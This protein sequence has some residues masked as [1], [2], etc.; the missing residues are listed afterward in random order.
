MHDP[1]R[2]RLDAIDAVLDELPRWCAMWPSLSP[3]RQQ[4]IRAHWAIIRLH[5][6][7]IHWNWRAYSRGDPC[8]EWYVMLQL[9]I[10]EATPM[11]AFMGLDMPL[12][13]VCG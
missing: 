1:L 4:D 9:R 13:T 6:D 10:E 5:L 8:P 12:L 7:H 2:W 3:D 11:I